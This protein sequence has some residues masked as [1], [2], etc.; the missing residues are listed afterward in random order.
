MAR[1]GLCACVCGG[2]YIGNE[3]GV[4]QEEDGAF[5][6]G[7]AGIRS[8]ILL[9]QSF[10]IMLSAHDVIKIL[11]GEGIKENIIFDRRPFGAD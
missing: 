4:S 1:V 3:A 5:A 11:F 8:Y 6:K 10:F 7:I 9:L 2:C